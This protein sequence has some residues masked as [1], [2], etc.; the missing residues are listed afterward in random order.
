MLMEGN[1]VDDVVGSH[2]LHGFMLFVKLF[3]N[4]REE[5]E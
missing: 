2:K 3:L 5:D 1:E 4:T